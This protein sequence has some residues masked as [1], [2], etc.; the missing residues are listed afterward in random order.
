MAA[1][2][3]VGQK[4]QV[5]FLR[6]ANFCTRRSNS[7][8]FI[9]LFSDRS[10]RPSNGCMAGVLEA[11]VPQRQYMERRS[12]RDN[13]QKLHIGDLDVFPQTVAVYRNSFPRNHSALN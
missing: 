7:A 10:V 13:S 1:F 9:P 2:A 12:V 8:P 4:R 5:T 3:L 11:T 6:R